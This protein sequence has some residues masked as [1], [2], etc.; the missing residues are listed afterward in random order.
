[1]ETPVREVLRGK[2]PALLDDEEAPEGRGQP[3]VVVVQV[4]AAQERSPPEVWR[5][6]PLELEECRRADGPADFEEREG[7]EEPPTGR[8]PELEA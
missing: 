7:P 2:E 4:A 1:M 8:R 5:P 6:V 3:V